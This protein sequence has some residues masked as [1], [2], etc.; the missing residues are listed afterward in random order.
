M[1]QRNAHDKWAWRLLPLLALI[2]LAAW[3]SDVRRP[4]PCNVGNKNPV[5]AKSALD[6][7]LNDVSEAEA[8]RISARR[9]NKK[10][11]RSSSAH[12]AG[13]RGRRQARRSEDDPMLEIPQQVGPAPI[14]SGGNR[15]N[16]NRQDEDEVRLGAPSLDS[17]ASQPSSGFARPLGTAWD[18]EKAKEPRSETTCIAAPWW[19]TF[20]I[21]H[22][23]P[24][25]PSH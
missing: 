9:R 16:P 7:I 18:Y 24:V 1:R 5:S 12:R 23:V 21:A 17:D 19:A 6:A 13:P 11:N 15:S 3:L 14:N 25:T 22:C 4:H 20:H 8:A 10:S 2:A